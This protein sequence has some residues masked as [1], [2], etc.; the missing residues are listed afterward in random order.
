M[1]CRHADLHRNDDWSAQKGEALRGNGFRLTQKPIVLR[2]QPCVVA[3]ATSSSA[4]LI[5]ASLAS[6]LTIGLCYCCEVDVELATCWDM[7]ATGQEWGVKTARL[8]GRAPFVRVVKQRRTLL[9]GVIKV[10]CRDS[11]TD[12]SWRR[13]IRKR[14][15][16]RIKEKTAPAFKLGSEQHLVGTS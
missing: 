4:L 8:M 16:N 15:K 1:A 2:K 14:P 9:N 5:L 6:R 7:M 12:R 11:M 13:R 10:P 3:P